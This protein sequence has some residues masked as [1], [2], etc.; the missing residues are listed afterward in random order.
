MRDACLTSSLWNQTRM[1]KV[2]ILSSRS[3]WIIPKSVQ[4]LSSAASSS[5]TRKQGASAQS[6]TE[7]IVRGVKNKRQKGSTEG[8]GTDC[9]PSTT[10][11]KSRSSRTP[12]LVIRRWMRVRPAEELVWVCLTHHTWCSC[13]G[14]SVIEKKPIKQ[15]CESIPS[16]SCLLHNYKALAS[17]DCVWWNIIKKGCRG[18]TFLTACIQDKNTETVVTCIALSPL[19]Q[20][21]IG[22]GFAETSGNALF[23]S[24]IA[25]NSSQIFFL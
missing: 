19:K 1:V 2:A 13:S 22:C 18:G 11:T 5:T 21:S 23:I 25:F 15:T 4:N 3:L 24:L 16:T 12:L 6:Y 9:V 14:R 17:T 8:S 20:R 10:I 7:K